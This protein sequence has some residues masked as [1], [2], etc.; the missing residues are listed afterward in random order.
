MDLSEEIMDLKAQIS[1]FTNLITF[2]TQLLLEDF[3]THPQ[4]KKLMKSAE[5][6]EANSCL[7]T[8]NS[9]EKKIEEGLA[10]QLVLL[11]QASANSAYIKGAVSKAPGIGKPY[12]DKSELI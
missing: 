10:Q 11:K 8:V 12:V 5:V 7:K 1:N 4:V 9:M 6:Q 2:Q 3:K